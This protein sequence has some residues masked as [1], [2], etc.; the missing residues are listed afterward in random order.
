MV[1]YKSNIG[2]TIKND[3]VK[4][5]ASYLLLNS[6]KL[7]HSFKRLGRLLKIQPPL[8]I[9]YHL[10]IYFLGKGIC[11]LVLDEHLVE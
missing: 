3:Q 6:R 5:R 11:T 2:S 8:Y 7:I 9:Y 4:K 10:N 1:K